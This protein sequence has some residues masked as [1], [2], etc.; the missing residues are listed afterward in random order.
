M[1]KTKKAP[2]QHALSM[3]VCRHMPWKPAWIGRAGGC[4]FKI[5]GVCSCKTTRKGEESIPLPYV[6]RVT[7]LL[8]VGSSDLLYPIVES[9]YF[10]HTRICEPQGVHQPKNLVSKTCAY[11]LASQ[12]GTAANASFGF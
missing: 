4:C 10:R 2:R 1:L 7:A 3:R 8:R 11:D 9:L 6:L 5:F 12:H